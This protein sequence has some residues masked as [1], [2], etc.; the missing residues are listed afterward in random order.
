[1][2][3]R[4]VKLPAS[5]PAS[6]GAGS[7][8]PTLDRLFRSYAPYVAKIAMRLLGRDDEVDDVVQDVFLVAVRG[9]G[10]VMDPDAVKGWLATIT[11]RTARRR[12]RVR[13]FKGLVGLDHST[14]YERIASADASPEERVLIAHLYRVLDRLPVNHRIAWVLRTM[15]GEQLDAVAKACGCS[16]ATAKRYIHA[17]QVAVEGAM[18][19]V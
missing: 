11:V 1:M 7:L 4:L 17:A 13:A 2:G 5:A 10:D 12:L 8:L 16:L 19:D 18:S 6:P 14:H 15:E 3:L 9:I